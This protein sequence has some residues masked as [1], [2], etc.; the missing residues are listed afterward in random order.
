MP[1][2]K[3][4]GNLFNYL[5]LLSPGVMNFKLAMTGWLVYLFILVFM[6]SPKRDLMRMILYKNNIDNV[7]ES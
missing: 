3:R 7:E 6:S 5:R 1:I 4:S 2:R